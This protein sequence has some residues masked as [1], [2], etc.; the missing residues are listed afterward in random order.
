MHSNVNIYNVKEI[1]TSFDQQF[2]GSIW[3]LTDMDLSQLL[4]DHKISWKYSSWSYYNIIEE[5]LTY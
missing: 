3:R 2:I 5:M 4:N 1:C